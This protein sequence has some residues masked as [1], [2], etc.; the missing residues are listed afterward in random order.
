MHV[1]SLFAMGLIVFM[2]AGKMD[3]GSSVNG[4]AFIAF[5]LAVAFNAAWTFAEGLVWAYRMEKHVNEVQQIFHEE[6][7]KQ[8]EM[9]RSKLN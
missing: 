5:M 7:E 6:V 9:G 4:V 8:L 2:L 3:E 1:A